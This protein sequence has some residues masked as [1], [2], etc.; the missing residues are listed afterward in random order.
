[1]YTT[2]IAVMFVFMISQAITFGILTA[3]SFFVYRFGLTAL[4]KSTFKEHI[5]I[6]GIGCF[7]L[8]SITYI[9]YVVFKIISLF[10]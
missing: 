5:T 1:M 7:T 3:V 9:T 2:H 4:P 10:N 8:F 6:V